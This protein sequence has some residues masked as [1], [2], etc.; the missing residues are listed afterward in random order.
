M[1]GTIILPI[2]ILSMITVINIVV[3]LYS[4]VAVTAKLHVAMNAAAG[5]S[6]KTYKVMKHVSKDINVNKKVDDLGY[7]CYGNQ[8]AN[9]KGTGLIRRALKKDIN[10]KVHVVKEKKLIRYRD[11]LNRDFLK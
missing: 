4:E 8:G 11:F 2:I 7:V 10:A 5:E 6:A 1:E 3:F 9:F